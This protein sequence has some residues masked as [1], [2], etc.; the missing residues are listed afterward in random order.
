[1]PDPMTPVVLPEPPVT[2]AEI[3][4]ALGKS[5]FA[6]RKRAIREHWPRGDRGHV[7][8][9]SD[10]P[11]DVR[12][13]IAA[14]RQ[15]Q[16][17]EAIEI[18]KADASTVRR[19]DKLPG[20][21]SVN[22][23]KLARA[24]ADFVLEVE[25]FKSERPQLH[26][27]DC[28]RAAVLCADKNHAP[29][30][31][32]LIAVLQKNDRSKN[33]IFLG[34]NPNAQSF[35]AYE[36][37]KKWKSAWLLYR[38]NAR[39]NYQYW[40]L[41]D[42]RYEGAG[43]RARK[44]ERKGDKRFWDVFRVKY[45][46]TNKLGIEEAYRDTREI[47]VANGWTLLPTPK[48]VRH[49]YEN[50]LSDAELRLIEKA[51]DGRKRHYD[52]SMFYIIRDWRRVSPDDCWSF[53]GHKFDVFG[54]RWEPALH[55]W[56]A[57]RPWLINAID[58]CSWFE[59]GSH[60]TWVPAQDSVELVIRNG[61][62]T[63]RRIAALFY[64]DNGREFKAAGRKLVMDDKRLDEVCGNLGVDA[65]YALP[66]NP[67]AKVNER[68]YLN[69]VR[70][71]EAKQPTYSGN[72]AINKSNFDQRWYDLHRTGQPLERD[73]RGCLV[74]WHLVPELKDIA[75]AYQIYRATD[76]HQRVRKGRICPNQSPAAKYMSADPKRLL[77]D[78]EIAL[79]FLR[80]IGPQKVGADARI[81][82]RPPGCKSGEELYFQDEAL[83]AF[84]GRTVV[85]KYD[86]AASRAFA[87]EP[88]GPRCDAAS[89]L[90]LI[91][92]SGDFRSVPLENLLH[93]FQATQEEIRDKKRR[94]GKWGRS[95]R[96]GIKHA[97]LLSAAAELSTEI[98]RERGI[99]PGQARM[100]VLKPDAVVA[101]AEGKQTQSDRVRQILDENVSDEDRTKLLKGTEVKK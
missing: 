43:K 91:K 38:R 48:Q 10:L 90:R 93:P 94:Y 35:P 59:I 69:V 12:S 18:H 64:F 9:P 6:W 22:E 44:Y 50:K 24:K 17:T 27:R 3:V 83:M 14:F 23:Q 97:K 71:F 30:Y 67:R 70:W 31:L 84:R 16:I 92:C 21:Y 63:H 99:T 36:N 32:Q 37:W 42:R 58:S 100:Y 41:C 49:Y 75:R 95:E 96:E 47:A 13:G 98:A 52:K 53:D 51:R 66:Y 39:D 73:N 2:I 78:E 40:V 7:Y 19:H 28:V 89:D 1:M 55:G 11:Q 82:Y 65:M 25:A 68:D 45:E 85:V 61:L 46:S 81:W 54:R 77:T 88:V 72:A 87:Y 5:N 20:D 62:E 76:H 15:R 4:A 56:V 34:D 80:E 33:L 29:W 101:R 79:S 60:F 8:T 74:N 26:Y 57:D 86:I